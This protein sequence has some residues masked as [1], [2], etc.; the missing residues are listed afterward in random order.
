M[1]FEFCLYNILVMNSPNLSPTNQTD[2][3]EAKRNFNLGVIN[4]ALYISVENMMDPTLVLVSFLSNLTSSPLLLGMLLPI[5]DGAWYLPQLWISGYLQNR[6]VKLDLYRQMSFIRI[7]SWGLLAACVNLVSDRDLLLVAF[8]LAFAMSSLANGMA[9][10]PFLE[11][12]GKTVPAGRR[13][14]FFAWR[15]GLGGIGSFTASLLVRW[16]LS[17]SSPLHFPYNYGVIVGIFFVVASISLLIYNGVREAPDIEV[18]P[19]ANLRQQLQRGWENIR[20]NRRYRLFWLLQSS[21]ILA[22]AA[23][24]FYALHVQQQLGGSKAMVGVYLVVYTAANL[25]ANLAFGRTAA[26]IGY[27]RVMAVGAIG[28]L[29]MASLVLALELL[30]EPLGLSPAVASWWLAP[31]FM[32]SGLRNSGVGVGGNSLLLEIAPAEERSLYVGFTN[33]LLG[34]VLLITGLTGLFLQAFGFLALVSLAVIM[35]IAALILL[36]GL[37]AK[38]QVLNNTQMAAS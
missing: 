4:G 24:P 6:K 21:L 9:G 23:T 32:L 12:V 31:V 20:T 15:F 28:G 36:G 3:K 25:L 8:L 30:A 22:G 5:R 33:S 11:V 26:R 17:S 14:N 13:G 38:P 35:H 7:A 18:L 19:Q 10:L 1:R 27:D 37:K 2:A 34:I 29:I 16:L